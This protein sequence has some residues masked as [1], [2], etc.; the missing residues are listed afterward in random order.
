M[1]GEI[2][3]GAE[4]VVGS[5]EHI[6]SGT[7]FRVGSIG[8]STCDT[9]VYGVHAVVELIFVEFD[10]GAVPSVDQSVIHFLGAVVQ[11]PMHGL[12]QVRTN[13][14]PFFQVDF[15]VVEREHALFGSE[16][17]VKASVRTLGRK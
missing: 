4:R 11:V 6:K 10:F 8:L 7:S 16:S 5:G 2:V 9:F 14:V 13:L 17:V 12:G 15:V 1:S 3:S